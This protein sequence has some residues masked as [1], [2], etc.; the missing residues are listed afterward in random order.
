MPSSYQPP[1]SRD[2]KRE[3]THSQ[4]PVTNVAT[5][6]ATVRNIL[7]RKGR[8]VISIRPQETLYKAV[9][10]L[11]DKGIGAL[12][13]TDANGGLVG[14]LSERDIVRK[15]ADTP[16]HTLP[17]RVEDIMTRQVETCTPDEPLVS[18]LRRMTEG[19]FRHMPVVDETGLSG[20]VTIGDVVHYRLNEL[21]YEALQ[22][23]QLIV[24]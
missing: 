6:R 1:L 20:I 21:E 12:I 3:T 8:E 11:R 15:L 7:D 24:G 16:G 4:T 18:V 23:K 2:E 22:L 14:V 5:E 17:Q 13:A 10:I 9:E 19:R